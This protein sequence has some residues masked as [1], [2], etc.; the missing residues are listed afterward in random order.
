MVHNIVL[1]GAVMAATWFAMAGPVLAQ[2]SA[3]LGGVLAEAGRAMADRMVPV[4]DNAHVYEAMMH[5]EEAV[6]HGGMGH[7]GA[8][9]SHAEEALMHAQMAQKEVTNP[10]LDEGV[11]ELEEAIAHGNQGHAGVAT[12]HAKSAVMHLNEMH[13]NAM[14]HDGMHDKKM[15]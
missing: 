15:N 2:G 10:H 9:V 1:A 6:K 3:P 13:G 8:I 4:V 5:A 7:A 12:G 14:H 11:H